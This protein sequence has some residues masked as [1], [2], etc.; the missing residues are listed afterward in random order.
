MINQ[1]SLLLDNCYKLTARFVILSVAE[2]VNKSY[3]TV[4]I[5]RCTYD[6]NSTVVTR[7]FVCLLFVV[8]VN[9]FSLFRL[10]S[11]AFLICN[12][13]FIKIMIQKNDRLFI[14]CTMNAVTI[15]AVTVWIS[16]FVLRIKNFK[17]KRLL[18]Q[19]KPVKHQPCH[20]W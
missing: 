17:I 3:V 19:A 1:S 10:F 20:I 12:S 6:Y 2:N 14:V 8:T 4:R 15:I 13:W 18:T 7:L 5:G 11:L 9:L 16:F